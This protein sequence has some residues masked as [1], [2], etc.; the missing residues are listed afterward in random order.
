MN[1][2]QSR[3]QFL[4]QIAVGAACFSVAS[5]LTQKSYGTTNT[6]K[7][8]ILLAISD[9]QSYPHASK[10]GCSFVN[11]PAFDRVANDG[12][13]MTNA[14]CPAPQC[15][16]SRASLL[17]GR[18]IWQNEEAG[19]HGS[20]FPK[21]W[22]VYTELLQDDGY[23]V[24][25]TGKPWQPGTLA[26]GWG[27]WNPAGTAYESNTASPPASGMKS[28]DYQSNFG[29]F[30]SDARSQGKPFCFWYGCHEP[31]RGYELNSGENKNGGDPADVDVPPYL[32]D[33]STIR[34]DLL[35]YAF[36]IEHFDYHLDEMLKKLTPEELNN[37]IVVV[38]ADNGMPFPRAKANLYNM[39]IHV[40]MAIMWPNGINGTGRT[41]TD[42]ISH[43]DLGPT[44]L[45]AVGLT[46]PASMSGN[47]LMNIF[48]SSASGRVDA[49][50][51]CVVTGR[52]RHT[53]ARANNVGYPA[54]SIKTD[55]Y[56]YIRNFKPNRWPMGDPQDPYDAVAA[57]IDDSPS[58]TEVLAS[59]GSQ[60]Y[61]L[62]C[63]KRPE[64]ELFVLAT[65]PECITNV[66]DD[67]AYATVKLDLWKKLKAILAAQQDPR[68]MGN[69]DIFDSYPRTKNAMRNYPGHKTRDYNPKYQ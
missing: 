24:G 37:T 67:P 34:G 49:T 53:H 7:P 42:F 56:L 64:E 62:S 11:T 4:K 14:Y 12:I 48:T 38:T 15:S 19:T 30:L 43:I 58:K 41:V 52:E 59:P 31:H 21:K 18:N 16:P 55:D 5:L 26:S 54:R 45:E 29:D 6:S 9:D 50:R 47:S 23:L 51:D 60:Y 2:K 61:N 39:G 36:E 35:D 66:A 63:A 8:N 46:V 17:T 20:Y 68:V 33:N 65:D 13:L 10:Y 25:H 1:T 44:F 57:D 3:R 40:P 28:L 69:G 22:G 27:G 32:P